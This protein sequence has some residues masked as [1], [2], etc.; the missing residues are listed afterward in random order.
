MIRTEGRSGLNASPAASQSVAFDPRELLRR[1]RKRRNFAEKFDSFSDAYVWVLAALIALAYLFSALF[2]MLFVLLGEGVAHQELP[3]AVWRMQ[4]LSFVLLMLSALAIFRLMIYLGPC[5]LS[6]AKADWW[7]PLP[8]TLR[9]IRRPAWRNA[10]LT[11]LFASS[12]AGALWLIVML[13]LAGSLPL[14]VAVLG[15]ACFAA[16]GAG[17]A[18]AATAIQAMNRQ[19]AARRICD[20]VGLGLLTAVAVLWLL[21]LFQ[22]PWAQDLVGAVAAATLDPAAWLF[23]L[24]VVLALGAVSTYWAYRHVERIP[25]PALRLAGEHQ[26][27]AMGTLMQGDSRGIAAPAQSAIS[28]RMTLGSNLTAALPVAWRILCLRLLRSGGWHPVAGFL[29]LAFSLAATVQRIA[30]PLS[31]AAFYLVLCLI[32]AFSISATIAPLVSEKQLTQ[33]LGISEAALVREATLYAMLFSA[34]SLLL[35]TGGL[36]LVGM[37]Q[38]ER[39]W[40]WI[41]AI[42]V[43]AL[44][45]AAASIAHARR[46]E[47]DWSAVLG[48][49]TNDAAMATQLFMETATFIRAAATFSPIFCLVLSPATPIPPLL[50]VAA[51]LFGANSLIHVAG[52]KLGGAA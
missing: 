27:L 46:A 23:A 4:D 29:L 17:L 42:V 32:L 43:A 6:A 15:L 21:L 38:L 45:C 39:I 37:I 36:G 26:Q 19:A 12:F 14:P 11:G 30:N 18:N 52:R 3:S 20:G 25:G 51:M 49:A 35:L 44:G 28:R 16:A 40:L 10:M 7:L 13:G 24:L 47:R 41:A 8:V 50:W 9:A 31:A 1:A 22:I 2:G 34:I 5:G 33:P 48:G